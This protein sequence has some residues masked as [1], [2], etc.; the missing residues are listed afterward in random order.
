MHPYIEVHL[1]LFVGDL[2]FSKVGSD[3]EDVS[4][5]LPSGRGAIPLVKMYPYVPKFNVTGLGAGSRG[6]GVRYVECVCM[7]SVCACVP[8]LLFVMTRLI[9]RAKVF[10][11]LRPGGAR[12][13]AEA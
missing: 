11:V 9:F 13:G 8:P 4:C 6:L 10:E 3:S 12:K 2:V 1:V 7:L 5:F